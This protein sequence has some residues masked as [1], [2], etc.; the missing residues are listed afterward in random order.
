VLGF[1]IKLSSENDDK[2]KSV[3]FI[4][5]KD[6]NVMMEVGKLLNIAPLSSRIDHHLQF[7]IALKSN[8]PDEDM[9]YLIQNGAT[10]IARC[11]VKKNWGNSIS[12]Q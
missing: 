5:D 6:N 9:E 1:N 12:I 2:D 3:A 10:F 8:N 4:T 11:P 7:H